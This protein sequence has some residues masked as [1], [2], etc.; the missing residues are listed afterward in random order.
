LSRDPKNYGISKNP[1]KEKTRFQVSSSSP[2]PTFPL[3][4]DI[5]TMLSRSRL[6]CGFLLLAAT[7][8]W[9]LVTGRLGQRR[10]AAVQMRGV[11]GGRWWEK[12][13]KSDGK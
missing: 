3:P 6:L 10:M 9:A 5:G 8:P 2:S 1:F 11:K 7:R 4:G 12:N 13:F